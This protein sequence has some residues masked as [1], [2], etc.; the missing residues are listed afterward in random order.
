MILVLN[1][2]SYGRE[3]ARPQPGNYTFDESWR[4]DNEIISDKETSVEGKS[5]QL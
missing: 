5:H 1:A 4:T 2:Q 3:C